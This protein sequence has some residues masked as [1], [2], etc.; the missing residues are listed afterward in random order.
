MF[1]ASHRCTVPSSGFARLP[2]VRS[3]TICSPCTIP[4]RYPPFDAPFILELNSRFQRF[5]HG[6]NSPGWHVFHHRL[7]RL[8]AL[9]ALLG[10]RLHVLVIGERLARLAAHFAGF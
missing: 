3:A 6:G 1:A 7:A 8:L 2:S 4:I 5:A 10:T 9:A